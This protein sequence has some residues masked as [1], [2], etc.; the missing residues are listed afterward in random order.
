MSDLEDENSGATKLRNLT[1]NGNKVDR[2]GDI[3][4]DLFGQTRL[5]PTGVTI[6]VRFV[7]ATEQ[8]SLISTKVWYKTEI[9]SAILYVKKCKVNREVGLA[10]ASVHKKNMYY[11]ITRVDCK[12]FT[13]PVESLSAFKE[14]IISG[15][16]SEK[17]WL[18]T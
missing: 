4:D 1:A 11:P 2:I 5:L 15:Q 13:I 14:G 12:V 17:L 6:K 9:S 10:F 18:L 3:Y 16:L 8:F 7:M